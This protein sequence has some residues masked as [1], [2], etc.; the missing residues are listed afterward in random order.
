MLTLKKL[1]DFIRIRNRSEFN[2]NM[3]F[4]ADMQQAGI[5]HKELA[6]VEKT[7]HGYVFKTDLG[8]LYED[9][10]FGMGKL[11]LYKGAEFIYGDTRVT[12]QTT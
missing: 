4:A 10:R 7:E 3:Q 9:K 8:E 1:Q 2:S 12:P 11:A 5:D 6:E